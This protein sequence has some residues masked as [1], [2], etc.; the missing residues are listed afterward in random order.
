[1]SLILLILAPLALQYER[2]WTVLAPL[3]IVFYLLS[4]LANYT[5]LALLTWD[6]P[7]PGERTFSQRLARLRKWPGLRGWLCQRVANYLNYFSPG[8]VQ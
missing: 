1:M 8:H 4:A 6:W 2:G 3:A 5:E 7:R